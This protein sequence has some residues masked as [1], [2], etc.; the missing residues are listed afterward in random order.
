VTWTPEI[1]PQVR[2]EGNRCG[3]NDFINFTCTFSK[4]FTEFAVEIAAL[5]LVAEYPLRMANN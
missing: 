1:Y 2:K 4:K 5:T 3:R